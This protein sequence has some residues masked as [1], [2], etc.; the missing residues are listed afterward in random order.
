MERT[1]AKRQRIQVLGLVRM[2]LIK[3]TLSLVFLH[4]KWEKQ[5]LLYVTVVRI[6]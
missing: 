3:L 5:F 4:I 6:K 1:V 2:T